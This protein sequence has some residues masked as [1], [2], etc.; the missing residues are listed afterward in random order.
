MRNLPKNRDPRKKPSTP[1]QSTPSLPPKREKGEHA[2]REKGEKNH[3]EKLL[4]K[5]WR[6]P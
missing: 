2:K 5:V 3:E 4:T 1:L 6:K